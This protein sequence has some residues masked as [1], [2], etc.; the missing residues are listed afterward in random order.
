MMTVVLH[1]KLIRQKSG[2]NLHQ[3]VTRTK[4]GINVKKNFKNVVKKLNNY[5]KN[6][7]KNLLHNKDKDKKNI[8]NLIKNTNLTWLLDAKKLL[9][10][11]KN[12]KTMKLLVNNNVKKKLKSNNNFK[13]KNRH[14]WIKKSM[15]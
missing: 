7:K 4:S 11:N 6:I 14:K 8:C 2:G 10:K 9:K 15:N 5:K 3:W 1:K 12:F 13:K